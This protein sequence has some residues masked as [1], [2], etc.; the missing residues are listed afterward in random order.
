MSSVLHTFPQV[1]EDWVLG[2]KAQSNLSFTG[3][4]AFSHLSFAAY[5]PVEVL[6]VALLFPCQIQLQMGL[7]FLILSNPNWF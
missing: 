5:I 2:K 7:A 3:S 4:S 1:W 6:P